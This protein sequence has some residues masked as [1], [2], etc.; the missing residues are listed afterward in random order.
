[1]STP[2]DYNM[3]NWLNGPYQNIEGYASLFQGA[4]PE[5]MG[6]STYLNGRQSGIA[7]ALDEKDRVRAIF[8]YADG[9]EDFRQYQ[10][11]LP[12]GSTFSSTRAEV[13][14]L[15]GSPPSFSGEA[16]GEG[17]FA[18]E[19]SFDRFENDTFYVRFEYHAGDASIRLVTLGLV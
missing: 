14:A 16:G 5:I 12:A 8:L 13:C 18:I 17:I 6:E 4:V 1:V 9:V 2:F 19:H 11:E 7:L 15:M 3:L 10:A